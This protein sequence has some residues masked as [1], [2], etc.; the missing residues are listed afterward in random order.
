MDLSALADFHRVAAAGSLGKASRESGRPKA[1][2]S[3]RIRLL[4]ESLGTRLLER[5]QRALRLTPEGQAL[6]ESTHTLLRDIE[7]VGQNLAAGNALPRGMLKV[8]APVLFSNTLGGRLAAEFVS[9]YPD[10]QLEWVANDRNV[11]LVDDAFDV[12]IRVNPRADSQLVGRCFARDDILVVA[13]RSLPMP[14]TT[15][16]DSPAA[17]PAVVMPRFVDDDVWHF[18]ANGQTMHL[19]PIHRLRLSTLAMV[20]AAVRAGIGAALLPGSL[21]RADIAEGTLAMWGKYPKPAT[22]LWVLHNSRRLVS[23]K[24]AVFVE[25]LTGS[26][27]DRQL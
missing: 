9:R 10:V 27:P 13:P 11:D 18:E 12:A 25:F 5:G 23:P 6:Y 22:E 7:E 21:V 1:T 15:D 16:A 20:R 24:V 3:R 4:E 14:K 2:L 8:S 19:T 26:F 17:V